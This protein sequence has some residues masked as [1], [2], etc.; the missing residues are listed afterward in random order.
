MLE[1]LFNLYENKGR[2]VMN[3][4]NQNCNTRK[5]N[6]SDILVSPHIKNYLKTL[7]FTH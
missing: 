3:K 2:L 6:Y 4:L 7:S 5:M 1:N